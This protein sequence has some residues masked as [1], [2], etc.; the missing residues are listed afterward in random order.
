MEVLVTAMLSTFDPLATEIDTYSVVHRTVLVV[1]VVRLPPPVNSTAILPI[2]FPVR[3]EAPAV[4]ATV[5]LTPL[6]WIFP[7][8]VLKFFVPDPDNTKL[9]AAM[10][11]VFT[12]R[13]PED[14]VNVLLTLTV[15]LIEM[16]PEVVLNVSA[17]IV[18]VA[19]IAN[20]WAFDAVV[21]APVPV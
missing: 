7:P 12:D 11:Y 4:V 15:W 2:E 8:D 20:D 5:L 19:T 17:G 3:P 16:L 21:I 10:L 18:L 13:V 6:T 1:D 14:Q 9:S